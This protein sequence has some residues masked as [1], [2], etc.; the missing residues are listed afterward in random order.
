[1]GITRTDATS[2]Y[3]QII[4]IITLKKGFLILFG[5]FCLKLLSYGR[6]KLASS[7]KFFLP[8]LTIRID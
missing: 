6:S 7:C 8:T 2:E 1:M 3:C 5:D 4:L